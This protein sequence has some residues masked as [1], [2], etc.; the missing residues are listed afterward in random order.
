MPITEEARQ[1]LCELWT[2]AQNDPDTTAWDRPGLLHLQATLYVLWM[3][4][5]IRE[6][7]PAAKAK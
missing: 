1:A 7:G 2:T 5:E 3:N 6:G 4:R